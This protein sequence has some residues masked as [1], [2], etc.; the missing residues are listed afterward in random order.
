MKTKKI[1]FTGV[2]IIVIIA[3]LVMFYINKTDEYE[4]NI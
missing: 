1:I 2:F 4:K 3:A